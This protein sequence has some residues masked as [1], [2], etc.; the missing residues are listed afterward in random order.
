MD[1]KYFNWF[2]IVGGIGLLY[3]VGKKWKQKKSGTPKKTTTTTTTTTIKAKPI[4]PTDEKSDFVKK[5]IEEVALAN[6]VPS[7]LVVDCAK[8]PTKKLARN[9]IVNQRML[10]REKMSNDKRNHILKMIDY[11]ENELESRQEND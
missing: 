10:N 11:M 3:Y 8:M 4:P 6:G 7:K 1:K 5:N 9:I 2:V